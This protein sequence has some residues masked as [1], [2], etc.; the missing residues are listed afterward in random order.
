MA[1]LIVDPLLIKYSNTAP[2]PSGLQ[3]GELAYSDVSD[4]LFIGT[5]SGAVAVGGAALIT[6]LKT[7]IADKA[8]SQHNHAITE[9]DQLAEALDGKASSIHTH[10]LIDVEGI[11]EALNRKAE[12]NHT[13]SFAVSWDS[14]GAIG[15]STPN[16]ARFTQLLVQSGSTSLIQADSNGARFPFRVGFYDKTPIGKPS[17]TGSR[18]GGGA[19]TSLLT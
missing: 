3:P 1:V 7:A 8:P 5:D 16:T 13:H 10:L 6:V 11:A 14:P 9:I 19:L 17:V 2:Q 15:T 18:G 4:T 12:I